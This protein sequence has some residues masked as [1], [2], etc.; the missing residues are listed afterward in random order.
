MCY[1]SIMNA[2]AVK[3]ELNAL[4]DEAKA[5]FIKGFFKAYEGGYAEGDRFLGITVPVQR[6]VAKRYLGLG[7]PEVKK[8]LA[9][10]IHEHR[11][12]GLEILVFR[13][14]RG[15]AVERSK[16]ARFYMHN[17]E[18][19]N[20]WDLVDASAPYILGEWLKDRSRKPLYRLARSKSLWKK[21]VAIVST[22]AF[23]RAGQTKDTFAICEMLLNDRHDLIHKACGW[24]LR[25]TGKVSE[26][27]LR[28]FLD[29]HSGA[30]P[31][32]MLRYA[33]ERFPERT[34]RAYLKR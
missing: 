11:F 12:V 24:M 23:I 1:D 16:I 20:N 28:R 10:P 4:A 30:M 26:A 15:E 31:R 32:T 27:G 19:V 8:L 33:I 18:R 5:N 9:S 14:E 3:K 22:L 2:D 34:R 21:R 7:L 25:E 29:D 17:L 6:K 13:F